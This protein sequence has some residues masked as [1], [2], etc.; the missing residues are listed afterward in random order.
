MPWKSLHVNSCFAI[1]CSRLALM[2]ILESMYGTTLGQV[3]WLCWGALLSHGSCLCED[4]TKPSQEEYTLVHYALMSGL[5]SCFTIFLHSIESNYDHVLE[6]FPPLQREDGRYVQNLLHT[7]KHN[8]EIASGFELGD[9][10]KVVGPPMDLSANI[11]A[12]NIQTSSYLMDTN[13]QST[14]ISSITTTKTKILVTFVVAGLDGFPG[15]IL[16]KQ[17]SCNI[18]QGS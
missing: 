6:F 15:S 8:I 10:I 14:I 3:P 13:P 11:E 17:A 16:I 5:S 2:V 12:N 18:I 9:S 7:L 4:V 1:L